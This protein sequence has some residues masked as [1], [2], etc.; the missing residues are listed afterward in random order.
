[1]NSE[2]PKIKARIGYLIPEFPGQ[3]HIWMWREICHMREWGTQIVIFSTKHPPK[4]VLARHSFA[5]SALEETVYL[6]SKPFTHMIAVLLWALLTRP[7]G[8]LQAIRLSLTL[9]TED[10]PRWR[11]NLPLVVVACI[12]ARSAVQEKIEHLHSHSCAKSAILAMLLECLTGIPYSLTLNANIE[13][14]GGA[15]AEK[16]HRAK[17]TIAITQW[18]L[19]QMKRDYP[20]LKAEQAILGRI[21]VDT[22]KW[23]PDAKSQQVEREIPQLIAVGRL[24]PSKGYDVLIQSVKALL[25]AEQPVKLMLIGEGPERQV[26]ESL[27]KELDLLDAVE[28]TGSLA[29]DGIIERMK[30]ADI[31]VLA[32]HREP[33]G[34][35]SM[36]AMAMEVA[37]IATDAGG[38]PEIITDGTDGL[39]VP[40]NNVPALTEAIGRLIENHEFRR[41]LAA[42]G[43]QTILERFDSRIGAAT[44]YQKLFGDLPV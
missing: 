12:L 42:K 6:W 7:W 11:S 9:E 31:F 43:R 2:T 4:D 44:L 19:D 24:H 22:K 30:Q 38:V 40:P 16:F 1:M 41:K 25:D 32:S 20:N 26:L 17:F 28:F 35:V 37:A 5:Q 8:L 29:E 15:M 10:R 34:V 13:W 39:L 21:G 33:L 14:W 3:T 27:V 18:L 36:E 23:L